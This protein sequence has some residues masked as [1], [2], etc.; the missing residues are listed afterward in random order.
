M[1]Q[2]NNSSPNSNTAIKNLTSLWAFSEGFLGGILNAVKIP[3]KG[4][5]LG[6]IS[7]SIIIFIAN[8]TKKKG[9]ILKAGTITTIVKVIISP[10]SGIP[11]YF[12]VFMQTLLGELFFFHRKFMTLS[13][14]LLGIITSVLSSVQR[15]VILTLLFGNA[16][17]E[18]VDQFASYIYNEITGSKTLPSDFKFSSWLIGVYIFIHAVVGFIVGLYVSRLVKKIKN[19]DN[20]QQA[21]LEEFRNHMLLKEDEKV[22]VNSKKKSKLWKASRISL[23]AFLLVVL[24]LSYVLTDADGK[25]YFDSKSVWI[26]LLRSVVIIILW[27]KVIGP[28]LSSMLRKRLIKNQSK[29]SEEIH[30]TLGALPFIKQLFIFGWKNAEGNGFKKVS[31]FVTIAIPAILEVDLTSRGERRTQRL[32]KQI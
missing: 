26:M 10:Y 13:G 23:Y 3:F 12:A 21:I 18:T 7:V 14:I 32:T 19:D 9:A 1:D 30:Y 5:L 24:I 15:I 4:L 6:N 29:Y 31:G 28:F 11:A 16:F 22:Q 25:A 20:K 8:Y 27:F 2:S 17:W